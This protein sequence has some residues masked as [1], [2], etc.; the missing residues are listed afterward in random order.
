MRVRRKRKARAMSGMIKYMHCLELY[1]FCG[2][3]K[4]KINTKKFIFSVAIFAA[5]MEIL[6]VWCTTN[7]QS[8]V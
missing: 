3:R 2:N 4:D 5:E 1:P 7:I 6:N 8:T